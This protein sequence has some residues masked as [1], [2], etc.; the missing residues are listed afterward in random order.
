MLT[1]W[2][3]HQDFLSGNPI[4]QRQESK[5]LPFCSVAASPKLFDVANE[6]LY[7]SS[8]NLLRPT[9][10]LKFKRWTD[11][12]DDRLIAYCQQQSQQP[13]F[14]LW[15][16][17]CNDHKNYY[18]FDTL[19]RLGLA[20]GFHAVL[21][22]TSVDQD[23][24]DWYQNDMRSLL[25]DDVSKSFKFF[26]EGALW[27]PIF[28][29]TAGAYCLAQKYGCDYFA[30]HFVGELSSRTIRSYLVG[31]PTLLL[32]QLMLGCSRPCDFRSYHSAWRPF[33][34]NNSFSGHAFI[35]ATPFLVAARMTDRI[36]LK[37]AFYV[38]S[39]FAGMSRINDDRHY[40]SQVLLGWFVAYLS[41]SAI[42]KT[43][44]MFSNRNAKVFPVLDSRSVGIGISFS[45]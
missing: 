30:D 14:T 36:W 18:S 39:T 11:E 31:T 34:D 6:N 3:K 12:V 29:I 32:G 38:C 5:H 7:F 20:T 27:I 26:G 28:G 2:Q 17:I 45:R 42:D 8:A 23:V 44:N 16:K 9:H 1:H 21:S 41:V 37:S 13:V 43:E 35:G 19:Y 10:R 40:L 15:K 25:A 24:R 22:N 4:I 33:Q